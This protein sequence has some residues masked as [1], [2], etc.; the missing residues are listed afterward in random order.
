MITDIRL[1]VDFWEHKK[2]FRL[3]RKLGI[4]GVT[5]LIRLW[6]WAGKHAPDGSLA[7]MDAVDVAIAAKWNGDAGQFVDCLIS[8]KWVDPGEI[9]RL[10]DWAEHQP[11]VVGAKERSEYAKIAGKASA[12]AR[13]AKHGTAQ[14]SNGPRTARSESVERLPNG[15]RTDSRTPSPSPLPIPKDIKKQIQSD[16]IL[17][18]WIAPKTWQEFEDHRRA[19]KVPMTDGARKGIV[20][21]LVRLRQKGRDA[22]EMLE[23]AMASGWR[24]PFEPAEKRNGTKPN[25]NSDS[26]P[27][28]E[29]Y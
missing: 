11:W 19:L 3:E 4:A 12:E 2:T 1:S 5:A 14:P 8:I 20:T 27:D 24:K 23:F 25:S 21:Q 17:P 26:K 13:R 18:E 10:H 28:P 6:C 29:W 7:D 9:M 15:S 16:F 22:N